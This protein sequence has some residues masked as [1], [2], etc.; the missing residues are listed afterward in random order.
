MLHEGRKQ[1]KGEDLQIGD[2]LK[3]TF[4]TSANG[5]AKMQSRDTD[6]QIRKRD[7]D[8]FL[9]RFRI[10]PGGKARHVLSK[11]LRS[12]RGKGGIE[13]V[14][15]LLCALWSIGA[16]ETVL[17]FDHADHGEN[18][19]RFAVLLPDRAEHFADRPGF[20]LG[21]DQHAGVEH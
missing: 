8:S 18:D 7:G 11:R 13:I 9:L 4:V 21:I 3:V 5:V 14:S 16:M 10:D 6:Q 19:F 20:P 2:Q 12:N 17:H 1:L 15:A